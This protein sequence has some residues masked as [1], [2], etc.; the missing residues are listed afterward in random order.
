MINKEVGIDGRNDPTR[1]IR[2]KKTAVKHRVFHIADWRRLDD[3]I[4]MIAN[5]ADGHRFD[6]AYQISVLRKLTIS[7][8]KGKLLLR[9]AL[10]AAKQVAGW[11]LITP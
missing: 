3:G 1:I 5:E 4:C 7:Y 6:S 11:E 10:A 2:I 9:N 8:N